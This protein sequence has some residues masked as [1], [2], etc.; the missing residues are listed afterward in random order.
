TK[1]PV[2]LVQKEDDFERYF[3]EQMER[4]DTDYFDV[5]LIH[6]LDRKLWERVRELRLLDALERVLA[7]RRVRHVGFSFHDDVRIFKQIV[8]GY[9]WAICQIQYNYFDRNY[10]AG[11]EGL[12]YAASKGLGVVVMEPLRG[13]KLTNKI[14]DQVQKIWDLSVPKRTPVEWALRWIWNH[15]E[16][17]T[18]LSGM[19]SMSQLKENIKI[20]NDV[21]PFLLST[22]DLELIDRVTEIYR[23]MRVVDCT[24][25]SY[26]MPCPQGVNI[27]LNFTLYNDTSVFEALGNAAMRYNE[28]LSPEQRASE[29]AACGECEERCPQHIPIIEELKKVHA[30]L[31][32]EK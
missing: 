15:S 9:D 22:K 17:S 10:Q 6:G 5:Y 27:P 26:C 19:S 3:N 30:R 2:W 4:L 18:L 21:R 12:E 1:L 16:V 8:D 14:P 28:M 13:G 20:A 7:A 31:G 11:R 23:K 29:C 32:R 25:C 24:A